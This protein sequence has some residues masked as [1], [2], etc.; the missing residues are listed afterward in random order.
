[1][2]VDRHERGCFDQLGGRRLELDQEVVA[3]LSIMIALG[4]DLRRDEARSGLDFQRLPLPELVGRGVARPA[5]CDRDGRARESEEA[6]SAWQKAV[7]HPA[8]GLAPHLTWRVRQIVAAQRGGGLQRRNGSVT[9]ASSGGG[10]PTGS[11][12]PR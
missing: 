11:W 5:A 3:A 9:P 10:G 4:A 6:R 12:V 8:F 2:T 7:T 1:M